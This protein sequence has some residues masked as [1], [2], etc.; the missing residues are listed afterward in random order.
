MLYHTAGTFWSEI[1]SMK[2]IFEFLGG[3]NDGHVLT[4]ELGKPS[5]AERHY[6]FSNR[7]AI[8]H[9]F[10]VAS[11]WAVDSLV[12][13]RL[14][15]E[16]PHHFQRHYYVVTERLASDDEVWVRAKY[17]SDRSSVDPDRH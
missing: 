1:T 16:N 10:K 11:R 13:D 7:G 8:G 3:P 5:D 15:D 17:S 2:I 4:G 9:R 14:Q 12:K 6:L